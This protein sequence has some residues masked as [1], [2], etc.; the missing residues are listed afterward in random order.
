[1][2]DLSLLEIYH[3]YLEFKGYK[4]LKT[5]VLDSSNILKKKIEYWSNDS[6]RILIE[7]VDE[8][9]CFLYKEFILESE[10]HSISS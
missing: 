4:L 7:I 3:Q 6:D 5:S 10:F 9:I 8:N 2:Q 1:M